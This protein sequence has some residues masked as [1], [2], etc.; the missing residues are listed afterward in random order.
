MLGQIT[1]EVSAAPAAPAA[2]E[3]CPGINKVIDGVVLHSRRHPLG[4]EGMKS[5]EIGL[6]CGECL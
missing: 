6:G 5:L 1:T 4:L 2:L 3:S